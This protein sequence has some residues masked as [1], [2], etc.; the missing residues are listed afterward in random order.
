M[1]RKLSAH[2]IFPVISPPIKHGI[3]VIDNT[4]LI[5]EIIDPGTENIERE[6]VEFFNGI[7]IPGFVQI[8]ELFKFNQLK[9]NLGND[10]INTIQNPTFGGV[11]DEIKILTRHFNIDFNIALSRATI[12]RSIITNKQN[13]TGSLEVG[14]NPGIL[15]IT[16]FDYQ[17]MTL[18]QNSNIKVLV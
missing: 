10:L 4:G 3:I 14:K 11:F 18:T 5:K 13:E 17:K 6:K 9:G 16:S 8:P 12:N 7:L 15:L 1:I 2:Y